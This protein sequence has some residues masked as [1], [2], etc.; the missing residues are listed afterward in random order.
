MHVHIGQSNLYRKLMKAELATQPKSA[1]LARHW[2][3]SDS[4]GSFL[5]K[6][7][8]T[9]RHLLRDS[10]PSIR[11]VPPPVLHY[12]QVIFTQ[13]PDIA[14][15]NRSTSS[16][17]PVQLFRFELH[18]VKIVAHLMQPIREALAFH[19]S[20]SASRQGAQSAENG[21][22]SVRVDVCQTAEDNEDGA[23]HEL[24]HEQR[25]G[26]DV[27]DAVLGVDVLVLCDD[28]RIHSVLHA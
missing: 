19:E 28:A 3:R 15:Q 8:R 26:E 16:D 2:T 5:T 22:A 18:V 24:K 27:E 13:L 9:I 25:V 23:E 4:R 1:Q 20:Q 10:I 21:N 7:V 17:V 11:M 6:S 12:S 14:V